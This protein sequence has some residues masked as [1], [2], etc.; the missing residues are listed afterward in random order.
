MLTD[1]DLARYRRR[2]ESY[3]EASSQASLVNIGSQDAA[4]ASHAVKVIP[5]LLDEIDRLR[6]LLGER[7]REQAEP[8]TLEQKALQ[9][10]FAR[11]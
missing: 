4:Y 11:E 10:T 5:K 1:T 8:H 7:E 9:A 2:L 6:H 3:R